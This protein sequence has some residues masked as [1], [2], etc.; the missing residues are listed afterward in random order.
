MFSIQ[1]AVKRLVL[2]L[3]EDVTADTEIEA[4][5]DHT[6]DSDLRRIQA[7]LR[8]QRIFYSMGRNHIFHK[9]N[10]H[11]IE[12]DAMDSVYL[13][14]ALSMEMCVHKNVYSNHT[15]SIKGRN[16]ICLQR[17]GYDLRIFYT[18]SKGH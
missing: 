6:K 12:Q 16:G 14:D 5:F 3:A 4:Q 13:L 7:E 9:S 1:A 2:S 15:F 10:V 11:D 17:I 18:V 8:K